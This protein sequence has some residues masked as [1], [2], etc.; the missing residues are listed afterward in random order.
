MAPRTYRQKISPME[1]PN[2]IVLI[3][4]ASNGIGKQL[5]VDL[6]K[7]RAVVIGCGRSIDRLKEALKEVR[8]ASP[9]SLMIGCDV[10]D[11]EQV[12]GMIGRVLNDYGRVDILINNAGI[13]MRKPFCE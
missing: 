3:T 1:F 12:H 8:Q 13:G 10:G 9:E 11:P 2:Q 6:A 4:G 7:R 5:A